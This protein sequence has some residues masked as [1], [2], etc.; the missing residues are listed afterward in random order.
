RLGL[1]ASPDPL[2]AGY[3]AR[4][5]RGEAPRPNALWAY[6]HAVNNPVGMRDPD[7][8]DVFAVGSFYPRVILFD[9]GHATDYAGTKENYGYG[10]RGDAGVFDKQRNRTTFE[11]EFWVVKYGS[12]TTYNPATG[13]DWP[14][15]HVP[16]RTIDEHE[17]AHVDIA[18]AFLT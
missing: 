18:D 14:D 8:R 3:V 16:S 1:W 11:I 5:N 15:A 9:P 7:G 13:L 4:V 10:W 12:S 6:Q 17:G 2:L